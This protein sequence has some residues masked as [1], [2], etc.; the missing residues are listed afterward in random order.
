MTDDT[1]LPVAWLCKNAIGHRFLRFKKP[2]ETYS[3]EPLV[4]MESYRDIGDLYTHRLAVMLECA[5]LDPTGTWN[6]AH[7][8]LEEY[9]QAMRQRDLALGVKH[10]SALGRD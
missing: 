1:Y 8:L 2:D 5:L 9:R 10:I 7:A 3:P 6:D 4:L